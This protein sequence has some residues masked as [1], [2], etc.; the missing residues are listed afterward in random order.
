MDIIWYY[1]S[2]V[3]TKIIQIIMFQLWGSLHAKRNDIQL[4]AQA[5]ARLVFFYS[6]ICCGAD[7][8]VDPAN[9]LCEWEQPK[10]Y[11]GTKVR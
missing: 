9:E 5:R 7:K 10:Q 3:N 8:Y 2:H 11:E 4:I 1:M 6:F